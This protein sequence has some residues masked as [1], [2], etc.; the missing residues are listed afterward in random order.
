MQILVVDL[1]P[2]GRCFD[3][4]PGFGRRPTLF[5]ALHEGGAASPLMPPLPFIPVVSPPI[6][7]GLLT[8]RQRDLG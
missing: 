5:Q 1:P 7:R 4:L 2:R 6:M 8:G 3:P